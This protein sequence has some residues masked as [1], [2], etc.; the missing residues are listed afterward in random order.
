M[1]CIPGFFLD[2]MDIDSSQYAAMSKEMY[3]TGS[4]LQVFNRGEDYLDKPPLLFW[5]ASF[6]YAIFGVSEFA[7]RFGPFLSTILG[8]YSIYGIVKRQSGERGGY[9]GAVFFFTCQ[10]FFLMNHDLRTDTMLTAFTV[11]AFWQLNEYFAERKLVNLLTGFFFLGLAMLAKGPVGL[12]VAI[13]GFGGHFFVK[14]AWKEFFNPAYLLGIL[15]IALVLTPMCI[16]LYE[17]YDSQPGKESGLYFYFWKQSFGRITGENFWNNNP[18]ATF[19]TENFLWS[20]LPWTLLSFPA[21]FFKLKSAFLEFFGGKKAE[22]EEYFSVF[23]FLFGLIS[24][25]LSKYQLPHYIYVIMPLAAIFTG[26][27]AA[28]AEASGKFLTLF[29][30]MQ[31]FVAVLLFILSGFLTLYVFDSIA[32][33]VLLLFILVFIASFFFFIYGKNF[34]EK[35]IL[36]SVLSVCGLNL[37]LNLHF[38]P[39]LFTYQSGSVIGRYVRENQEIDK[40]RYFI[41]G[42]DLHFY[43]ID[44]YADVRAKDFKEISELEKECENGKLWVYTDE[45]GLSEISNNE[46]LTFKKL[47]E[48]L[49]FHVSTLNPEFLNPE[50]RRSQCVMV[51]ML[52]VEKK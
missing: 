20:F 26:E 50:T 10:V 16:G 27:Y 24:L 35:V 33:P 49:R 12:I 17:Q 43:A 8:T 37:V 15:V 46:K 11:A 23:G 14:K 31:A 45:K 32:L 34:F 2:V 13:M 28:K 7:F 22:N 51:Y 1:V 29:T 18:H 42:L 39:T 40:K 6:F 52:E 4:Y 48:T 25:S 9:F 47:K 21:I 19:L 41:Y 36:S 5:V 3:E 44:F 30:K 38:Y